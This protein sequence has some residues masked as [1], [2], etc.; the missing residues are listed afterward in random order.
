MTHDTLTKAPTIEYVIVKPGRRRNVLLFVFVFLLFAICVVIF[1]LLRWHSEKPHVFP[2]LPIPAFG[3]KA[4]LKTKNMGDTN[5]Y[6]FQAI[7]LPGTEPRFLEVLD[8][9]PVSKL[10]LTIHLLD[11]DGFELCNATPLLQRV[12]SDDGK[13]AA[14]RAEGALAN[15]SQE[16]LAKA[17]KWHVTGQYPSI[18]KDL[19][20]ALTV[21][22]DNPTSQLTGSDSQT[23]AIET[24]DRGSFKVTRSAEFSTLLFWKASDALSI[25]CKSGECIIKNERT[26]ESVH[27]VKR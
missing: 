23:G 27:A 9:T 26:N 16:T 10:K 1:S 24:L 11:N 5:H 22:V 18:S 3:L 21:G 4:S 19:V 7:P 6:R 13:P 25:S 15:C 8:S 14:L 12:L 2:D 20:P 17:Q